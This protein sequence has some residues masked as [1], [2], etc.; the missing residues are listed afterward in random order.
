MLML[1]IIQQL[2]KAD[3]QFTFENGDK[4]L[5]GWNTEKKTEQEHQQIPTQL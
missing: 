1:W 5:S 4:I 3:S 2:Q